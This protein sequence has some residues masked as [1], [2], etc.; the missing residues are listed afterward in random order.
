MSNDRRNTKPLCPIPINKLVPSSWG[1][2]L[3]TEDDLRDFGKDLV[4]AL[5][6]HWSEFRANQDRF[7]ER[8][9]QMLQTLED[10][11]EHPGSLGGPQNLPF[12]RIVMDS[13]GDPMPLDPESLTRGPGSTT[14]E[15]CGWCKFR[16]GG[17]FRN[18]IALTTAC[19]FETA[20][21]REQLI[22]GEA[23]MRYRR[24]LP[25]K[26]NDASAERARLDAEHPGIR[27]NANETVRDELAGRR[28]RRFYTPCFLKVAP[29][30]TLQTCYDDIMR[31]LDE[32]EPAKEVVAYL[33]GLEARAPKKPLLPV[34]RP[35]WHFQVNNPV[36]CYV[37]TMPGRISEGA[38]VKGYVVSVTEEGVMVC[39]DEQI[40][41]GTSPLHPLQGYGYAGA[42]ERPEIMHPYEFDFLCG[43]AAFAERWLT[44]G[45]EPFSYGQ[46]LK[47]FLEALA[48][49]R[50]AQSPA[51]PAP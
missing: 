27:E 14:L 42:T 32:Q 2:Q 8:L 46:N 1:L 43:D 51:T 33:Y 21:M 35:K 11:A 30:E 50:P 34:R 39:C 22:P 44:V 4:Q 3:E 40:Q 37:G 48:N 17:T 25:D 13:D 18:G 45:A 23:I 29:R 36:I 28:V 9:Q 24:T 20:A 12:P 26:S 15:A 47:E 16:E 10:A 19:G 41:D 7:K 31:Q 6:R 38:F 5:G 49:T